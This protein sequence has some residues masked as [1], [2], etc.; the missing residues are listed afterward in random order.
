VSGLPIAPFDP[1]R[2]IGTVCQVDPNTVRV[3]LPHA[4]SP[5]SGH[6]AGYGMPAGQVGEFVLIESEEHAIVGRI[7][8]VKLL[9]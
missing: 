6:H 2:Y 8:E 9:E 1:A 4:A 5:V 7:T 3:N